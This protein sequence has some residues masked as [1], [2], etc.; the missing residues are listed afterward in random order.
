[1]LKSIFNRYNFIQS[2]ML[3]IAKKNDAIA[4]ADFM[5]SMAK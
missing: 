5:V 4:M 3:E 2:K 1:M